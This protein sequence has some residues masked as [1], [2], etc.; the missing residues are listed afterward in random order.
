MA[1]ASFQATTFARL[2][3]R[4]QCRNTRRYLGWRYAGIAQGGPNFRLPRHV[5]LI[6][7]GDFASRR[8]V[9][10]AACRALGMALAHSKTLLKALDY[11]EAD[12]LSLEDSIEF[13]RIVFSLEDKFVRPSFQLRTVRLTALRL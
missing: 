5:P 12:K 10:A 11:P 7:V 1:C 2:K 6:E 9:H 3:L 8:A 4:R 13:R